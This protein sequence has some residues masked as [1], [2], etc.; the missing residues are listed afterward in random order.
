L[1]GRHFGDTYKWLLY[2]DD[3]T[4]FFLD[5][6]MN[7]LQHLD[8]DLPYFLTGFSFA[9]SCMTLEVSWTGTYK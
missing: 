8:P 2:G 3:D 5:A 1:H 7:V 6:A 4:Y 9:R